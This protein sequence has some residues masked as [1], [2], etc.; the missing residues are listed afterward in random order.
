M[1]GNIKEKYITRSIEPLSLKQTEKIIDQMNNS[2]CKIN[3]NDKGMGFFVKI[4]YKSTLLPVLIASNQTI[5]IYD[6][7]INKYISL[8]L[9]NDKKIKS[10][11]L[12]NNRL[13]YT[14]EKINI[15]IIEILKK[16]NK[17]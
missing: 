9:N 4:P 13:T 14:N 15:S 8:Y 10:I 6:I 16:M 12:D 2:V 1:V 3:N 11:K 5:N 17:I 7:K